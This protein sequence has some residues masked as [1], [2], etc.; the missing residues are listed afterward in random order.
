M[1]DYL[2]SSTIVAIA[3]PPG[4][5]GVAVLRLSGESSWTIASLIFSKNVSFKAGR[6]YHGWVIDPDNNNEPIDEVL[7]LAFKD[8]NSYTGEDVIEIHCHGSDAISHLIL[9]LCIKSGARMALPGEFTKRAYLNGKLDLTQAES[10]MDLIAAG[11]QSAARL[12]TS[13][14]KNRSLGLYLEKIRESIINIQADIV[15]HIDFPDEVDAP[16]NTH[17]I[18]QLTALNTTVENLLVTAAQNQVLKTGFKVALLGR[19]NAGKSSVFNKLLASERAIVTPIAGTTRDVISETLE[20]EG[21]P[22]TLVDT[23]GIHETDNTVEI[24]GIERSFQAIDE[25]HAA[26]YIVDVTDGLTDKDTAII[27]RLQCPVCIVANKVDLKTAPISLAQRYNM[28]ESSAVT[29]QGMKEL[30]E[31]LK[32]HVKQQSPDDNLQAIA[33][34][35]RQSEGLNAV[36]ACLSETQNTL[37]NDAIP[38]DMATV[39]LTTALNYLGQLLGHDTTEEV[40]TS[41]FN[42]FC[43]GK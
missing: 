32:T 13:N 24:M 10:V 18:N 33:L 25:A 4:Q 29:G 14:L 20:I 3:T 2:D 37:E 17:L 28:I 8:P 36:K 1:T 22:I 31:W 6:F 12:A 23:A 11:H 34:N 21:I 15:A 40:L 35:Q 19:P 30:F 39:P 7:L 16:D 27:E 38:L 9:D 5:G 43:V 41:V 26:L 42:Q